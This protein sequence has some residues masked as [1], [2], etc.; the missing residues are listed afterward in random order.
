MKAQENSRK[1]ERKKERKKEENNHGHSAMVSKIGPL[2]FC[3]Q[4]LCSCCISP[5]SSLLYDLVQLFW[6]EKHLFLQVGNFGEV[7][8]LEE[9]GKN[10][11]FLFML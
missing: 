1:F 11:S 2:K 10:S 8:K 4:K 9:E 6:K 7:K 3:F 5:N